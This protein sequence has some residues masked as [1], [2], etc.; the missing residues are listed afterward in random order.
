[1]AGS[2]SATQVPNNTKYTGGGGQ[3]LNAGDYDT[4]TLS[5]GGNNITA[6][7]HDVITISG[8]GN[9]VAM[10]NYDSLTV[11]DTRSLADGYVGSVLFGDTISIYYNDTVSLN[12]TL[13]LGN[14]D[15]VTVDFQ[16]HITENTELIGGLLR[17]LSGS[18]DAIT[19]AFSVLAGAHDTISFSGS[20]QA[21]SLSLGIGDT[22][23]TTGAND[24]ITIGGTAA[25]KSSVTVGATA[26]GTTINGGLGTDTFTAGSGYDGGNHFIGSAQSNADGFVAI[27]SCANYA[28][29]DCRVTVNLNTGVGHGFDATGTQLWTDTYTNIQQVKAGR[30]DGN[31]LT[32]SDSY[33][34]ELK[35]GVGSTTYHGGAA[36][37]RI[38]WSSAG[39]TGLL[40]GR[41]TD[42]AYSGSGA[43]EF[44]WRNSP[45]GKGVGNLNET[46]YGFN[47]AQGDDLNLSELVLPGFS[48]V[49]QAF[50]STDSNPLNW[51]TISL[52]ANG[53][54][55]NVWL[56][57]NGIG[58]FT[59]IAAVLKNDNLFSDFGV[60]DTSSAGAGQV[61]QDMYN[62]GHLVLTHPY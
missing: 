54:D 46:I 37:D 33:F 29:L 17:L 52:S 25:T 21:V 12:Y 41:G 34:C 8:G 26:S 23:A 3:I 13:Q 16:P 18:G 47:T 43:D 40:D 50:N 32:G 31:V 45:G 20:G 28:N 5:G 15:S 1:M 27:G 19:E 60:T 55:T 4:I 42:I 48:G 10:H 39:T 58:N 44:Y 2:S 22:I 56:D 49:T 61:V 57:R 51:V 9:T 6:H 38:I 30:L 14:S 35:G 11:N 24:T 59:Q 62:T 36:G 7:D 53:Q